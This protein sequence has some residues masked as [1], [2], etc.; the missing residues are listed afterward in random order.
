MTLTEWYDY[1]CE[2]CGSELD[3]SGMC[4]YCAGKRIAQKVLGGGDERPC[5][6]CGGYGKVFD[7]IGIRLFGYWCDRCGGSGEVPA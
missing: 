2:S 1:K 5:P 7:H 4:H 6:R 3:S